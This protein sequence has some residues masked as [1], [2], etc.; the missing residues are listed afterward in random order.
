MNPYNS[1]SLYRALSYTRNVFFFLFSL[2]TK[3]PAFD[4][5]NAHTHTAPSLLS[6]FLSRERGGP[7][8][9]KL[10]KKV[11][12][13]VM[14]KKTKLSLSLSLSLSLFLSLPSK[15]KKKKKPENS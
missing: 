4:E 3:T 12:M 14:K 7:R 1:L 10:K 11:K 15:M 2:L 6:P 9:N 5:R 13:I 8:L